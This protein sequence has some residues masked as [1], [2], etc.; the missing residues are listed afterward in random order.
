MATTDSFL[1]LSG[2]SKLKFGFSSILLQRQHP[3]PIVFG[4]SQARTYS[5]SLSFQTR[6]TLNAL[7]KNG[8]LVHGDKLRGVQ[9]PC[10]ERLAPKDSIAETMTMDSCGG[11]DVVC[12]GQFCSRYRIMRHTSFPGTYFRPHANASK[13]IETGKASARRSSF[14]K[15][16]RGDG[17]KKKSTLLL[18]LISGI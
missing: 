16:C 11:W 17:R 18:L 14:G 13:S 6:P 8:F 7:Y 12:D 9:W 5:S 1:Q 4:A 10:K 3:L 2:I 15:R